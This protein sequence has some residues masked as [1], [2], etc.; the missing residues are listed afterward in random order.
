MRKEN[1]IK[2]IY[3]RYVSPV[4]AMLLIPLFML[5]PSY[6]YV[7]GGDRKQSISAWSLLSGS[8]SD[9]RVI[10][11]DGEKH[12]A[13]DTAFSTTAFVLSIVL[14]ILYLLALA[15]AIYCAVV[16]MRYFLSSNESATEKSRTLFITVFPNRICISIAE[17]LALPLLLLPYLMPYLFKSSYGMNVSMVLA[18]PDALILGGTLLLAVIVLSIICAPMERD[19][20]ADLFKK[21]VAT[22]DAEEEYE[23][24]GDT[25][26][27]TDESELAKEERNR[28]IRELLLGKKDE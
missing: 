25:S 24:E 4:V 19:F 2:L 28:R 7:A 17:L 9:S 5:I 14:P 11:F 12:A 26:V 23:D 15:A 18:A 21:K 8:F 16:A 1:K 27:S 13:A 3:I 22:F 6:V 20:D 10:L